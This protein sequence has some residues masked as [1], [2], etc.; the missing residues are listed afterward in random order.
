MPFKIAEVISWAAWALVSWGLVA[1]LSPHCPLWAFILIGPVILL[2]LLMVFWG[3]FGSAL[4]DAP[5]RTAVGIVC[6]TSGAQGLFA[7]AYYFL[8]ARSPEAFKGSLTSP[9]D[10]AY[11]SISTATTTGM[12][13]ISPA[14]GGARLL[15]TAQMVISVFLIV[16]AVVTVVQRSLTAHAG[17]SHG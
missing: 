16:I 8:A 2:I 1:F 5:G 4:R 12:G 11:F 14:S 13:D 3:L 17:T 10:A 9:I 7:L 6:L 15:V